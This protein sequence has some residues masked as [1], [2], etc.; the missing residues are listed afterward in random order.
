M[1][2]N[3][4]DDLI[5]NIIDDFFVNVIT[6]KKDNI[7]KEIYSE[8]NFVKYQNDINDIM[9]KYVKTINIKEIKDIVKNDDNVNMIFNIIKRYITIYLFIV[10]GLRYKG[11]YSTYINNIVEFT[12]NQPS[13]N[14][15]IDN[16]FNS[17]NNAI[18]I[19]YNKLVSEIITLVNADQTK[20]KTYASRS[21]YKESVEILN[22]LGS[23]FI[24]DN[25]RL[26]NLD[27]N[28]DNQYHNVIKTIIILFLYKKK[29]KEDVFKILE[30]VD[31]N[32][33]EYI[34]IEKIIPKRDNIDYS[35]IEALLTKSEIKKGYAQE[36]WNYITEN[37]VK[38]TRIN[39][40]DKIMSLINS[41]IFIPIVEDILLYHRDN[42]KYDNQNM[43]KK[44]KEDTKIQY[45]VNKIDKA[46]EL[47]TEKNEKAKNEIKKM[48]YIPMID[49]NIVIYNNTED[50]RIIN[51]LLNQGK[52]S[53]ENNE[54]YN[55]LLHYR[56]YP[57]VNFKDFNN[58][59]FSI[60]LNNTINI[61]RSTS[62][63]NKKKKHN[64]TLEM[65]T[66]SNNN[67]VNIVGFIL[68]TNINALQCVKLKDVVDIRLAS[69]T[70][71]NGYD[72][73][74]KFLFQSDLNMKKHKSTIF[75]LFNTVHDMIHMKTYEKGSKQSTGEQ[76]K[77]MIAKMHDDI[78]NMIIDII[79][80]KIT[81]NK[82][83]TLQNIS[84]LIYNYENKYIAINTL[85]ND[86][87]YDNFEDFIYNNIIQIEPRYDINDDK[88]YGI[89]DNVIKMEKVNDDSNNKIQTV[90]INIH[91]IINTVKAKSRAIIDGVCQHNITWD[92]I[93]E[94]RKTDPN[95][96][97]NLLYDFIERYVIE[98]IDGEYICKSCGIYINIKNYI[99]DGTF[100]DDTKR[101]ITYSSPI[102]IPLEDIAEYKK[103]N[104][105]IRHI[106]KMIEKIAN[107][108]NLPYFV[109]VS[110]SVKF[111]RRTMTKD[112]IDLVM[113]NNKNL[114]NNNIKE[115]NAQ[116]VK[117]YGVKRE[118][119]DLFVFDLDN[120]IFVFSSK[121]K[122]YYKSIKYNNI[123]TY[124]I[125]FIILEI[126][127]NHVGFMYGDKK[128]TCNYSV[129]ANIGNT[130][131][132]NLKII[133]NNGKDTIDIKRYNTLCYMLYYISCFITKYNIW[134]IYV[135]PKNKN[136]EDNNNNNDYSYPVNDIKEIAKQNM[137]NAK[138]NKKKFDPTIQK[139]I[140]HTFVDIFNS[141]LESCA[142]NTSK[143]KIYDIFAS[144]FYTK[145]QD[146][147]GNN[148]L[149][150]IY[151][152][153]S[154][155]SLVEK[156]D[157]ILDAIKPIP[158][159]KIPKD[160]IYDETKYDTCRCSKQMQPS[161]STEINISE[162]NNKLH[163]NNTTN[164]T[165]G[166]FHKW[167]TGKILTCELCNAQINEKYNAK[168]TD[169]IIKNLKYNGL[170]KLAKKYCLDGTIHKYIMSEKSCN[171]C[172]KCKLDENYE[173]SHK[174]LDKL[175]KNLKFIKN[176]NNK[177]QDN[178]I[179]ESHDK[180]L[181]NKSVMDKLTE[182]YKRD[183]RANTY[184]YIN[185]FINNINLV[186]DKEIEKNNDISLVNNLYI[187]DHD[188]TGY[189]LTK[190]III[191][192]NE[193]KIFH[194][195]NH[196]FFKTDV[197]YYISHKYGKTEVYYN[198]L[199]YVLLGYRE[200]NKDYITVKKHDKKIKIV[201][202]VANKIKLL[203]Y[204]VRNIN[205]GEE[206]D[207]IENYNIQMNNTTINKSDIIND[208]IA[209][210]KRK[211]IINLKKIIT[212]FQRLIYRIKYAFSPPAQNEEK[213]P[214][215]IIMDKHNKKLLNIKL[216]DKNNKHGIFK[217]WK[218]VINNLFASNSDINIDENTVLYSAENIN[219][220][221]T[222][223]N[224]LLYY[225]ITE[226]DKLIHFNDIIAVKRNIVGFIIDFIT[227]A[228]DLFRADIN[229]ENHDI[230]RFMHILKSATYIHDTEEKG[231]G[232]TNYTE[233][234]YD[235]YID[236]DDRNATNEEKKE[237]LY[238]AQEE[239]TAF[240]IDVDKET[241]E[242]LGDYMPD[243]D[244]E[245]SNLNRISG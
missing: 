178:K 15:R 167:K 212:E 78:Q 193:N 169:E 96:Y 89:V 219:N 47:Y 116:S 176:Q 177:E 124:I 237:K 101:F 241:G 132:D 63:I 158:L 134:N 240:D 128:G 200:V 5:S 214:L 150:D 120:S 170:R 70:I 88:I 81:N 209:D 202:S 86:S 95:K 215:D 227:Y 14:F 162:L 37:E 60:L 171:V 188:Q 76:I 113:T 159:E 144:K 184:G 79:K 62:F 68:P 98:N 109:G 126:N 84:N 97:S 179:T 87:T 46:T 29:E 39:N 51:K 125:I 102:D 163:V 238:D 165:T 235:E 218:A 94:I 80:K 243:A 130:L 189:A 174:D 204:S 45:I 217:H 77:L 100:D 21:E 232:F 141:I 104:V 242:E 6:E 59:G 10:I 19:K 127:K 206:V 211:R 18:V 136:N 190:P 50:I 222:E 32:E 58:D 83:I 203:G 4:I 22:N 244:A 230:K 129:F 148:K 107:I 153:G 25:F 226:I 223:G 140:I 90:K 199:T 221:D 210:I 156:K 151:D 191:L 67:V 31:T 2:V 54:Y 106:D 17:E 239:S 44:K 34:Y 1:Y 115:R 61:V 26:S 3:K 114:K 229:T 112:I 152:T 73:M 183:T 195:S 143:S 103:F 208:I 161:N 66:G 53:I 245:Y 71:Y 69:K 91:E 137:I 205:L 231:T 117:T 149:L 110:Y 196:P 16:F 57:Y 187:L 133:K 194:K 11:S 119:S 180:S 233:G 99:M 13:F 175:E 186:S 197:I 8:Q 172:N 65:R 192:E 122:D 228:Y 160:R 55:D 166:D 135:E 108:C 42:E 168:H 28:I 236:E 154:A 131:F 92:D 36:Y 12:K 82:N 85:N 147:Y 74:H 40:D 35:A 155:S 48:F 38:L 181:Y 23:D 75:W 139:R 213:T 185:Q 105:A 138:K 164:C 93:T 123:L 27:N 224:M 182:H 198:A 49:R 207:N 142:V 64:N 220:F 33:E 201:L 173:I 118:L 72:L 225:I 30:S 111:R 157:Y 145:I 9:I 234:I 43:N 146:I 7:L 216:E 52:K 41:Q 24:D 121:E 56:K 20:L